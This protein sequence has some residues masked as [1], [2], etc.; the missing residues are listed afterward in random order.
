M[1]RHRGLTALSQFVNWQS[2]CVFCGFL[3]DSNVLFGDPCFRPFS[4]KTDPPVTLAAVDTR[5][6]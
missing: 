1:V 6:P 5:I 4:K 3:S 2:I